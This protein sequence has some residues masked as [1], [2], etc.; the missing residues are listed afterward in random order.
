MTTT[1]MLRVLLLCPLFMFIMQQSWAQNKTINGKV[2]DDKGAAIAGASVIVKGTKIGTSTDASGSF[3]L[4]APASAAKLVIT[5]V[6]FGS[7]EVDITS[8]SD[9]SVSLVP[10]ATNLTDVVVVGYGT[11]R[12]KDLTGAV[13]SVKEKDFN[14]GLVTAPDQLIQG[15]VSGVQVLN[16]SG[17]PGGATTVKIRGNSSIRAGSQPLYVVDGVP[18]DGRSARPGGSGAGIGT[19]PDGNPL[20]F[21]NPNDIASMEVLKDASATAIYGSRAAYG[22]ILITTKRGQSGA[23]KLDVSSS[24]G[25]SSILKRLDVL[26]ATQYRAALSQYGLGTSNDYGSSVD[27]MD[28]IL[29]NGMTQNFSLAIGGGNENGRY[30]LSAGYFDQNGII[31]KSEFKKFTTNFS[32]NFK[33]LDSK[34]LGLDF[35]LTATQTR[36][37]IP[38]VSNDAGFTGNIV[39]QALQWNPTRPLMVKRTSDGTDSINILRG[40]TTVNPLAMSE[41]Y[42][43]VAKVTTVL[44]SVSPYYKFTPNLEYRMLASVNYASGNRR[45][46]IASFINLD[47]IIDRGFAYY[48][49]NELTTYQL[50]QTL[51]FNKQITSDL[52]LTALAGYEYMKFENK[53]I[54]MNAKDFGNYSIPYTNYFQY[55]SQGTRGIGSFADP[56]TELQSYFA[57]ATVNFKDRYLLTGTFRADGSTKFGKNNRYGYFPSFAAAW[58]ISNESFMKDVAFISNL[59]LRAGWG[60]T[61]SQ[62]I[63]PGVSAA[64]YSFTGIGAIGQTNYPNADLKWQADEQINVGIDFAI[65]KG[66]VAGSVNYFNKKTTGLLYPTITPQPA[67]PGAPPT[68]K[69]LDATIENKGFEVDLNTTII[70]NANLTWDFGVNASFIKNQVSNLNGQIATGSLS[71]QGISGAT[72]ELIANGQPIN[73]FYTKE[74]L[75]LDKDGQS[76]YTDG[77]YV[78]YFLGNPNPTTLLGISTSLNYKKLSVSVNMNGAFGQK[79][80]NNTLN[81]VIPIGNIL[82]G[83]N[84]AASLLG[85][86]VQEALSNPIA[87]SSRYIEDGSYLKLANATLSYNIGSWGKVVKSMNVFVTGQNLLVFTNFTGFD[88]EVNTDKQVGGVPSVGIEYTPYPSA[89]S[90]QLGLN[91]SL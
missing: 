37:D 45:N 1:R 42:D 51:N 58:N 32:G 74:Y 21:I 27:A 64:K 50:T 31:K 48:A 61:G 77:G 55:S 35:N 2:T 90:F 87:P 71:G 7:S 8:A 28:A 89:R 70:K 33:F 84:I 43:D 83:R 38:P 30:R 46:Q 79:V 80:Y 3:K 39:G 52:N 75:G 91:F 9:V 40:S 62:D 65:L 5:Y 15:K 73:V 60:K 14:K 86:S 17:Q 20:N 88:P 26:D 12:K 56:T 18:L 85:G 76:T 82:G 69:N 16:N 78:R 53:G 36:E 10:E 13:A 34:K 66:R 81:S 72:A 6:G 59:K 67:P 57:R 49:N 47:G 4:T 29:Q 24:V 44:A 22:V 41:A 19:S 54:N 63:P 25:T 23:T 11:S 68:W